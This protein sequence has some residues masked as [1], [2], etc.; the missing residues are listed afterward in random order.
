MTHDGTTHVMDPGKKRLHPSGSSK[1]QVAASKALKQAAADPKQ[2]TLTLGLPSKPLVNE[3]DSGPSAVAAEAAEPDI[4][5]S[6]ISENSGDE[7]VP[8][9][10]S[11]VSLSSTSCHFGEV[12]GESVVD[13]EPFCPDVNAF[14]A[15]SDTALPGTN[16]D[17]L[18]DVP[19]TFP[20]DKF[21][22]DHSDLNHKDHVHWLVLNG[23]CRP[24]EKDMPDHR[25]PKTA[26]EA[27]KFRR[28][29]TRR[30]CSSYYV[31]RNCLDEPVKRSWLA[32]SFRGDYCYC[33]VCWLFGDAQA[34]SSA[35]VTGIRDWQHLSKS[36]DAHLKSK[37]HRHC[38]GAYATYAAGKS[39]DSQVRKLML[40]EEQK[41]HHILTQ[42][43][44]LLRLLTGLGMPLRGHRESADSDNPGT[45]LSLLHFMSNTDTV[46]AQHLAGGS[47]IKYVSKTIMEEQIKLLAREVRSGITS[48]CKRAKFYTVIADSSPDIS[49]KDQM[50]V[51]LR[52][53]VVDR[54]VRLVRIHER[55]IGYFHVTDGT[56]T[57][58]CSVLERVLFEDLNL[59]H[60][61][62]TGQAY[63]GASVMS[64]SK[65]GVQA[66]MKDRLKE[67]GNTF[68]PYVHC[69][70]HQLNLVLVHAAES[71][72]PAPPVAVRRFFDVVQSVY[73]YFSCSYRRWHLL[74]SQPESAAHGFPQIDDDGDIV[75]YS[76]SE[77]T[78]EFCERDESEDP[79]QSRQPRGR[80]PRTLKSLSKTRWSAR[81]DATSALLANFGSVTES[82]AV[83]IDDQHDADE[84]K[85]AY[86]LQHQMDWTFLLTLVWWNDVLLI[87]DSA[88]RLL[89]AKR[90]DLFMVDDCFR[91]TASRIEELRSD[92]KF[93]E[94]LKQAAEIWLS[95]GF[96]EEEATFKEIRVRRKK[97]MTDE[98]VRDEVPVSQEDRYRSDVYFRVLDSMAGEIRSRGDGIHDVCEL[99]GFL[100]PDYLSKI[101]QSDSVQCV[102]KLRK[103]FPEFFTPELADETIAFQLLYFNV[104]AASLAT[105]PISYLQFIVDKE[106]SDSFPEFEVLLRLFITLPIGI[107]SAE[108]SFSVLRRIKNYLRSTMDQER[109][110]D[111][112]LLAIERE[113]AQ[114]LDINTIIKQFAGCKVRRGCRLTTAS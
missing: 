6:V 83:L 4:P 91:H 111:L 105:S 69:P 30:F 51:L 99:F 10:S 19:V 52:Y 9:H 82:L 113:A 61:Y 84:V 17:D 13:T 112:A 88:S 89:Q 76:D 23:A 101:S 55:F 41:W 22:F 5:A 25:F 100:H 80:Q 8:S 27:T 40:A 95:L 74:M 85:Q 97:R 96:P 14:D 43:F 34:Q 63:D 18:T 110:S 81:K 106:L 37:Q 16:A 93:K 35:W 57:G 73:N 28:A 3:G 109:T 92:L 50:A 42:Q 45:Y 7:D 15:E 32:Y 20:N 11:A 79:D 56:A 26:V 65:G 36:I 48:E 98:L 86:D 102:E 49:H 31:S 66:V 87:I 62:L 33:H 103:R 54:D 64:G 70:P 12:S 71:G 114:Q 53:V 1:R 59:E 60:K 75:Q 39:V 90:N 78:T 44:G 68:V 46:L 104:N 38:V 24:E 72:K 108:R 77:S 47:R 21:R 2:T 58:I 107:A 29:S 94:Y 67:K